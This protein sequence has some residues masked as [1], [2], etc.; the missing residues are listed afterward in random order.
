MVIDWWNMFRYCGAGKSMN[1]SPNCDPTQCFSFPNKTGVL[2]PRC[3]CQYPRFLEE[4][5][6]YHTKVY[7]G[8][9]LPRQ[10]KG[11]RN[12]LLSSESA[13]LFRQFCV[14]KIGDYVLVDAAA[15]CRVE[16]AQSA[17]LARL[18]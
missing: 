3:D 12:A 16:A 1:L 18:G 6:G 7:I 15:G 10:P 2:Y 5:R 14:S 13:C 11:D 9:N 8:E 4:K 17:S